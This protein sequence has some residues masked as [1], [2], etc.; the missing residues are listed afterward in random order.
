[1]LTFSRHTYSIYFLL[2]YFVMNVNYKAR[3][4]G[5]DLFR[6]FAI[7][8]VVMAHGRLLA[9]DLFE[10]M[11]FIPWIDG[12]ELFF[13]LSGFLIGS[14][15]IKIMHKE[16]GLSRAS[17]FNFWKRR[18]FRTLPNYYLIL[19]SNILLVYF[20]ILGGDLDGVDYKF[21]LFIHNFTDASFNFYWESWSLSIEEH[22]YLWLPISM[23]II[24]RFL[25]IRHTLLI[26]IFFFII[27]PLCYRMSIANESVSTYYTWDI[28]FRKAVITRLD[29]IAYGVLAAYVKFFYPDFWKGH[30]NK[31]FALG[32]T[33]LMIA[34]YVPRAYEHFYTQTFSFSVVSIGSMFLLPKADS[35]KAFNNKIIGRA[36]THISLI[37]YSMYLINLSIVVQLL[38]KYMEV[39]S[40]EMLFFRYVLYWVITIVLST[41]IYKFYEKPFLNLRDKLS[42]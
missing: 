7:F 35:L 12:V 5:L 15:L 33:T 30:Y 23:L 8:V 40:S 37:S 31:F 11:P 27:G 41:L 34:I 22:I 39:Q 3:V 2:E 29:A 17:L 25:S 10:F 1:M 21:F 20:G 24:G 9:G 6:A 36:V 26:T 32:L 38:S 42:K 16:E 18:W 4:Y 28:L 14:I 19:I 13:V